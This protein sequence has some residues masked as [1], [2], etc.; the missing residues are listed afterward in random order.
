MSLIGIRDMSILD[1]PPRIGY[2]FKPIM[3]HNE[4]IIRE[5]INR[6]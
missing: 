1:E 4:E 3:E 2:L 5:A 6:S